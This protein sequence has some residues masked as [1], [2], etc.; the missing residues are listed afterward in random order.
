MEE[1]VGSRFTWGRLPLIRDLAWIRRDEAEIP[2]DGGFA[3]VPASDSVAFPENLKQ[4][5][6][7]T[8]EA[9]APLDDRGAELIQAQNEAAR[10]AHRDPAEDY[11][12]VYLPPNFARRVVAFMFYLWATG[13]TITVVA[14]GTPILLGR[15][16]L[17]QV[18]GMPVHDG[19]SFLVGG[20]AAWAIAVIFGWFSRRYNET[21]EQRAINRTLMAKATSWEQAKLRAGLYLGGALRTFIWAFNHVITWVMLGF[22]MPLLMATVLQLYII[23]P[24]R[25]GMYPDSEG[26]VA[27]LHIWE[28]WTLGCVLAAIM[29][30]IGRMQPRS[31]LLR[32]WDSVSLYVGIQLSSLLKRFACRSYET[33]RRTLML[34]AH[35]PISLAHSRAAC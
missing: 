7:S 28:D 18:P 2:D 1:E 35:S 32:A 19:Y 27:T 16:I 12:I 11:Q 6:I 5:L 8:N 15:R 21:Q 29:V 3:R 13:S 17:D 24:I 34:N 26:S 25:V 30:R 10:K 9:G 14:L 33:S 22:V 4:M 23:L 31:P 20:T